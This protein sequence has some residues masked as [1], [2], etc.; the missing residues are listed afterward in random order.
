VRSE[1]AVK[2][3]EMNR[4]DKPSIVDPKRQEVKERRVSAKGKIILCFK[5]FSQFTRS[6]LGRHCDKV[7]GPDA[8]AH[9]ITAIPIQQFSSTQ[10]SSCR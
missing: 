4:L 7:N 1:A 8:P 9:A 10:R 5:S 2:H 3:H 6:N